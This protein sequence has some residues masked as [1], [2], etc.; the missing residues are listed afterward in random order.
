V[1]SFVYLDTCGET[2]KS[3]IV[4]STICSKK[5]KWPKDLYI[6]SIIGTGTWYRKNYTHSISK[7]L[8]FQ[9][10]LFIFQFLLVFHNSLKFVP[11]CHNLLTTHTLSVFFLLQRFRRES[12]SVGKVE[13]HISERK[14]IRHW[15]Y[16][17]L[18]RYSACTQ[19]PYLGWYRRIDVSEVKHT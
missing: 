2:R 15:N 8:I 13:S 19:F 14:F 3:T 6:F 17:K 4:T 18:P 1:A 5:T 10:H 7:D 9:F 12:L 11:S 16:T